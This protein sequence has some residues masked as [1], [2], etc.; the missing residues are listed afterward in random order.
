LAGAAT[1]IF[2]QT[3]SVNKTHI[4]SDPSEV[5]LNNLLVAAQNAINTQDYQTAASDYQEYLAKKPDDAQVHFQLGYAYTAMKNAREAKTQYEAA[6]SLDPKMSAA[7][8]N[9]GLTQL[10][11]DP[12]AAVAPLRKAVE[13]SPDQAD[14][15]FFLGTALERSGQIAPALEQYEAAE[16]LDGRNSELHAALGRLY[17]RTNRPSDAE[18]Q[19]RAALSL[20]QDF[21][22][23]H[24]GLAESLAAE[25]KNEAADS[26]YRAYFALKPQD[27][28]ARVEHASLLA[29]LDKDDDALA[30]LDRAAAGGAESVGAL[31]L[32]SDLYMRKKRFGDAVQALQKA[33]ALAPQ[34]PDLPALIGH[35]YLDEKAYSDAANELTAA[36]KMNPDANDVLENLV[37][38]QYG[39]KNCQG[40][41]DGLDLLSRRM[42]LSLSA[43]FIRAACYD[44]LG[45]VAP[46]LDAYKKFLDLNKDLNSDMYFEAAARARVLTRQLQNK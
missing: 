26:E 33:I 2:A 27:A 30:D 9:L 20:R 40:A 21:S 32:R 37:M 1:S 44:K 19:F 12:G 5:A 3:V 4:A 36:L 16:K 14:P 38:A 46:A 45:Q 10:S 34:D 25:K 6:I 39:N 7:Y 42:T 31:K 41:L 15:K 11:S 17:L 28:E 43:W 35:A 23:A 18:P 29:G 8:L 22:T 24:L 13:L